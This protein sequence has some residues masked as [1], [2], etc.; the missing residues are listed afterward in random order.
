MGLVRG[1]ENDEATFYTQVTETVEDR[2]GDDA[3]VLDW[4]VLTTVPVRFESETVIEAREE[5]RFAAESPGVYVDPSRIDE[6]LA[7]EHGHLTADDWPFVRIEDRVEVDAEEY[8]VTAVD[9]QR[10][11]RRGDADVV[12]IELERS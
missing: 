10:V 3:E 12:A 1:L 5:A 4:D 11:D 7:D 9:V 6:S 2:T 8:V